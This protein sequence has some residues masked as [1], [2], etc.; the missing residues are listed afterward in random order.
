MRF[1]AIWTMP[2]YSLRER[3]RNT[4]EWALI[5]LA[6]HLPRKLAYRSFIDTGARYIED[7]ETVPS[8]YYVDILQRFGRTAER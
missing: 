3:I 1:T 8:V 5:K 2:S 4:G 6:H 7:H